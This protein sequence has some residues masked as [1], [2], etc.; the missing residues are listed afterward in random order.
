MKYGCMLLMLYLNAT[1]LDKNSQRPQ[2]LGDWRTCIALQFFWFWFSTSKFDMPQWFELGGLIDWLIDILNRLGCWTA[3][4][5]DLLNKIAFTQQFNKTFLSMK[6]VQK[7]EARSQK[8]ISKTGKKSNLLSTSL[9]LRH[10]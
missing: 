9:V 7:S 4:L 5:L 10:L 1:T 3:E 8:K 2:L 6:D